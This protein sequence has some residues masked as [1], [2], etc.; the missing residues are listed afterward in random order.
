M[1][2]VDEQLLNTRQVRWKFEHTMHC[3]S[4]FDRWFYLHFSFISMH[5]LCS[6]HVVR[7]HVYVIS[8]AVMKPY[9]LIG[10][11]QKQKQNRA[12]LFSCL[13]CMFINA[14]HESAAVPQWDTD[15]VHHDSAAKLLTCRISRAYYIGL[16]LTR[17]QL[18][19]TMHF[20]YACLQ[21][22]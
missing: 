17:E 21:L 4:V 8:I 19:C 15:T 18:N 10:R 13:P 11:M 20:L 7:V 1:P 2:L 14:I 16:M 3:V 12:A 6:S 9:T 22:F 5:G